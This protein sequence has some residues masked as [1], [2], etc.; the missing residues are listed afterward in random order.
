MGNTSSKKKKKNTSLTE[1]LTVIVLFGILAVFCFIGI[2]HTLHSRDHYQEENKKYVSMLTEYYLKANPEKFPEEVGDK[3]DVPFHE[4]VDSRFLQKEIINDQGDSC[5][6]DSLV[7][8]TKLDKEEYAY[9]AFLYCGNE[10]VPIEHLVEEP[11]VLNFYFT[12]QKMKSGKHDQ[13]EK[14]ANYHFT[15]KASQNDKKIGI[16]H[17]RYTILGKNE[18]DFYQEIYQSKTISG[19]NKYRI[20]VNSKSLKDV[21]KLDDYLMYIVRID[22]V[23]DIGGE[24]HYTSDVISKKTSDTESPLCGVITGEADSLSWI[25]KQNVLEEESYAREISVTCHDGAG[26]G[27]KKDVFT[28]T[29]PNDSLSESKKVKYHYGARWGIVSIQ[30]N[31]D[32]GNNTTNCYVRVNVDLQSP[33]ITLYAYNASTYKEDRKKPAANAVT[34]LTMKD[35]NRING[36]NPEGTISAADYRDATGVGDEKWLNLSNYPDGIILDADVSDN[37]YLDHWTWEV[38]D[39]YIPTGVEKSLLSETAS[40]E[41]ALKETSISEGTFSNDLTENVVTTYNEYLNEEHGDLSGSITGLKLTL[42][43]KRYGRL[44][45]T[46]KAGNYTIIHVYANIDRTSPS[47]PSVHYRGQESTHEYIPAD[48]ANYTDHDHW[49]NEKLYAYIDGQKED[50]ISGFDHFTYRYKQQA[51]IRNHWMDVVENDHPTS[52]SFGDGLELLA[53]GTHKLSFK[54]CDKAGN[55]SPYSKED[56]IKMDMTAPECGIQ[57]EYQH[58]SGPNASGWLKKGQSITLSHTCS[59]SDTIYSSG[60][61]AS[62][63]ENQAKMIYEEDINTTKAGV[64]GENKGG[65]VWDYAGNRSEECPKNVTVKIDTVSPTCTTKEEYQG[66][67]EMPASGWLKSGQSVTLF[68]GCND[69][70]HNGVSSGCDPNHEKNLQNFTYDFDVITDVAGAAGIGNGGTVVDI[71]G[72]ESEECPTIPLKIDHTVPTCKTTI[73]YPQGGP[74]EEGWLG[75]GKTAIVRQVC[76]DASRDG[77]SSGCDGKEKSYTYDTEIDTAIA[78]AA[79]VGDSGGKVSDLAGNESEECPINQTV[80]IDYTPPVC[81][82]K[83]T[84][85]NSK[86]N[87][88]KSGKWVNKTVVITPICSDSGSK[89]KSGCR[90]VTPDIYDQDINAEVSFTYANSTNARVYDQAGNYGDCFDHYTIRIDKTAPVASCQVAGSYQSNQVNDMHIEN[91][92]YDPTINGS[93]SGIKSTSYRLDDS[94]FQERNTITLSCKKDMRQANGS[95]QIVDQAGNT[96]SADCSG[97]IIVPACCSQ[98]TDWIDGKT[99]SKVCGTGSLNRHKDSIYSGE[100]CITEE[101]GGSPCN[102]FDCCE[103]VTE[104]PS[105]CSASC[106][107][108]TR[109]VY[110]YSNYTGEYC[111]VKVES[112]QTRACRDDKK[113]LDACGMYMSYRKGDTVYFQSNGQC[114]IEDVS[115]G[116]KV[117]NSMI[118]ANCNPSCDITVKWKNGK[119]STYSSWSTMKC[120]GSSYA[121]CTGS[122]PS[123]DCIK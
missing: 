110:Q 90:E 55:C 61:N 2:R 73:E 48:E 105:R 21:V 18:E 88:Y 7:R 50:L 54:S 78:G 81:T 51:N 74:T 46:D 40:L 104:Q 20:D 86:G 32:K 99:C 11:V 93:S 85:N 14:E 47:T 33:T 79:G 103:S 94:N 3:V 98:T 115:G 118:S 117:N 101:T 102:Q 15:L 70:S 76:D 24:T 27:C 84:F 31:S 91:T 106:G 17:Y 122:C 63:E 116:Q 30:D 62:H 10:E 108:G 95:I 100:A 43:G 4:L 42:E 35:S 13:D 68:H 59:E 111:G 41:N 58:A 60:C 112:C 19:E 26:S 69:Q 25:N 82:S 114:D 36:I 1:N 92:S 107:V 72:N 119:E 16:H 87:T 64:G 77:V 80:K 37:L 29:F 49:T 120:N 12:D 75:I 65:Y 89:G 123:L 28:K 83:I 53:E 52:Y 121:F 38:N 96:A 66:T 97:G 45:V 56:Y 44:T 71:A 67:K 23:N 22:V 57:K 8:V 34:S 9:Q 109:S 6:K 5:M 113:K 39:S